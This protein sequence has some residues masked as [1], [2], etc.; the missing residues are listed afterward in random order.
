MAKPAK[1]FPLLEAILE[2]TAGRTTAILSDRCIPAP[3]GCGG[4]AKEFTNAKA[5]REY[6]ISG[7]CQTCQDAF[8]GVDNDG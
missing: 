1:K 6:T 2:E 5:V 8:F 3:L 7:F 4:P